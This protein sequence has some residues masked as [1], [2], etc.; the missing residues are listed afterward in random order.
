MECTPP[1]GAVKNFAPLRRHVPSA[2]TIQKATFDVL[3]SVISMTGLGDA[4][5][6]PI[7][8]LNITSRLY[9]SALVENVPSNQWVLDFQALESYV[10][11][12][13]RLAIL[14]HF[15]GYPGVADESTIQPD[16]PAAKQVCRN[17][18]VI[19]A[20][21]FANISVFGECSVQASRN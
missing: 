18:K 10:W 4:A 6:S 17:Q 16:S 13:N 12:F 3:A 15:A 20:G 11:A 9:S 7:P 19:E 14:N 1:T 5:I 21:S 2:N 8:F